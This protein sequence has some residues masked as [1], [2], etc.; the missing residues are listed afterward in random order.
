MERKLTAKSIIKKI[1]ENRNN[2]RKYGVNKIGLF[3]SFLNNKQNKRS[4]IDFLVSFD[5]NTFDNYMDT[6]FF[7]ERLFKKK[8]DLVIEENLKHSLEYVKEEAVYAK[9]V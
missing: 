4:D 1:E 8:I 5:K 9:R 7:L 2:L 3:G 6:K